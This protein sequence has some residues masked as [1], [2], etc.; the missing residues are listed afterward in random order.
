MLPIA[1]KLT[2][3]TNGSLGQ[4]QADFIN[5]LSQ[6]NALLVAAIGVGNKIKSMRKALKKAGLSSL[7][8]VLTTGFGLIGGLAGIVYGIMNNPNIF[9]KTYAQAF[10]DIDLQEIYE[11]TIGE[12]LPNLDYVKGMLNRTYI[13]EGNLKKKLFDQL[14]QVD[15]AADL[16]L[17]VI[18][19]L[20]QL[21]ATTAVASALRGERFT[22]RD[23]TR[24]RHTRNRKTRLYCSL[25][26]NSTFRDF[27]TFRGDFIQG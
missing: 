26:I 24:T 8:D 16:S 12:T 15:A 19:M 22:S 17:E 10:E 20:G 27:Q 7:T 1:N 18:E 6:L 25:H 9:I 4:F 21:P 23:S 11:R 2:P 14:E 3:F 13:P 5:Y